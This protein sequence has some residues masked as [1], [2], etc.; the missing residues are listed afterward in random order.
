MCVCVRERVCVCVCERQR[1]RETERE[2]ER[3]RDQIGLFL[4]SKRC[5]ESICRVLLGLVTKCWY[6]TDKSG[7]QRFNAVRG[8]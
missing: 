5:T 7:I 8:N 1:Q 3:E 4:F 6:V 2:R